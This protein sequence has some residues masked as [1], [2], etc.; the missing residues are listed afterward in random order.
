[1]WCTNNILSFTPT[2]PAASRTVTSPPRWPL[3]FSNQCFCIKKWKRVAVLSRASTPPR[4]HVHSWHQTGSYPQSPETI[5]KKPQSTSTTA[6]VCRRR[7]AE[8]QQGRQREDLR[9]P[10]KW[11]LSSGL[12]SELRPLLFLPTRSR[13][14][15]DVFIFMAART[16]SL[17]RFLAATPNN[18]SPQRLF[19]CVIYT[20]FLHYCDTCSDTDKGASCDWWLDIH[21]WREPRVNLD[22]PYQEQ[23]W[24]RGLIWPGLFWFIA[25]L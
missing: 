10:W 5:R 15:T 12:Q 23:A 19:S 22:S 17:R 25:V 6:I 21:A 7:P 16:T 20:L 24:H 11:I 3:L 9:S 1:M 2:P 8:R 14:M 18:S 13:W 4:L